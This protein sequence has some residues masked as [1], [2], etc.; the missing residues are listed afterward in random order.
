MHEDDYVVQCDAVWSHR[1]VLSHRSLL[2]SSRT[3]MVA[4]GVS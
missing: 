2:P 4:E 1:E 3:L